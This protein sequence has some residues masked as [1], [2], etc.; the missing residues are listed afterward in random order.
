LRVRDFDV[1]YYNTIKIGDQVWMVENL[2]TTKYRNGD[3]IG[4]TTPSTLD[5]SG[6]TAPKYQWAYDGNE[7]NVATYGRLYTWYAVTDN[8]NVCPADWHV[9]SDTEW[10][11]LTDYLT[12]NGYG[13]GGSGSDIAKSLAATSGWETVELAGTVGNNQASNNSSGFTAFPSGQ[14]NPS[15]NFNYIGYLCYWWSF[16]E[17]PNP[18]ASCW[19]MFTNSNI[20]GKV[21]GTKSFGHSV[22]CLRDQ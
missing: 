22:R 15:G 20:V 6:E 1:N 5:I 17:A 7:S 18:D 16:T 19:T 2:K 11:T 12:Y 9:P 13:F 21:V 8:R 10:T 4:T 14:R 3:L